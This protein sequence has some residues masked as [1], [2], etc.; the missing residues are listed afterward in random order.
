[1]RFGLGRP[2]A[3]F[4]LFVAIPSVVLAGILVLTL[5]LLDL[6]TR[7][8]RLKRGDWGVISTAVKVAW[9]RWILKSHSIRVSIS[10]P[11][12]EGLKDLRGCV[13][14][15]NH[16]SL[17]DI[18]ALFCYLPK[19]S[20][21][22]AKKELLWIPIFGWAS[23]LVGTIFI[24]RARGAQNQSLQ[25]VETYLKNGISIVMFPEGTRSKDGRLGPFKKGAFV[26][27]LK[28][29]VPIVPVTIYNSHRLLP[30]KS[31]S[32]SPGKIHLHVDAPIST[33]GMNF[34]D[35]DQLTERVRTLID[36]NLRQEKFKL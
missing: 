17:L 34:G 10:G 24:D 14:V 23:Y 31:F 11:G 32:I 26:F 6:F 20:S 16:S 25:V 4:S 2:S 22:I 27:A 18:P 15:A 13:F 33:Q 1:M 12:A 28:A 9:T 21:F 36:D 5:G 19:N 35:R 3:F 7:R 8:S 29:Q 30:K